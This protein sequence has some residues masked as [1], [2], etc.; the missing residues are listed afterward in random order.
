MN[1][2]IHLQQ[3]YNQPRYSYMCIGEVREW[4]DNIINKACVLD[5]RAT[6]WRYAAEWKH[7]RAFNLRIFYRL[8]STKEFPSGL[9]R[10]TTT[11]R[12][13]VLLNDYTAVDVYILIKQLIKCLFSSTFQFMI[14]ASLPIADM[15][16]NR[17]IRD[18]NCI[19]RLL[20][21]AD[22]TL[23]HC[24]RKQIERLALLVLW[25]L[26]V[27][28]EMNPNTVLPVVIQYRMFWFDRKYIIVD[29]YVRSLNVWRM[30]LPDGT[31]PVGSGVGLITEVK[32]VIVA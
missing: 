23:M 30:R 31:S 28:A 27:P 12:V 2:T 19:V 7:E 5:A 32:W 20:S 8:L 24:L 18:R 29:L 3:S 21:H 11:D 14:V 17:K 25:H 1:S 10:H 16:Y 6:K 26:H 13:G 15:K 9:W 22:S 4:A